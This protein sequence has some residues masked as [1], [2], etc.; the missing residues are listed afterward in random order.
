MSVSLSLLALSEQWLV[1]YRAHALYQAMLNICV[2]SMSRETTTPESGINGTLPGRADTLNMPSPS[3]DVASQSRG[4]ETGMVKRL[5]DEFRGLHEQRLRWLEA[6]TTASREELLQKKEDFLQS[7]VNDLTDQNQL[8]VETI[9]ELQMEADHNISNLGMKP[10]PSDHILDAEAKVA[11]SRS[12]LIALFERRREEREARVDQLTEELNGVKQ[13][14]KERDE[15]MRHLNQEVVGLRATQD[16]LTTT[17]AMKEKS[18][19]QLVQDNTLLEEALTSLQRKLQTSECMLTDVSETRDQTKSS[20][21]AERQQKQQ[22][23]DQLHQSRREVER[24]QQEVTRVHCAAEK[25]MQK[26]EM[27]KC[28]LVKELAQSKK[29]QSDCQTEL[30]H[31]EK[32]LEKQHQER[33]ELRAKMEEQSRECVHLNQTK[34]RLEAD[35]AESH[36]KLRIAHLEVR[37]RD[38]LILQ[39]RDEMK[40]AEQKHQGTQ[41]QVAA[42]E[43]ELRH[44]NH[45]VRGHQEEACQLSKRVRDA[46]RLKDQKERE[47][48]Q[49]HDQLRTSQQQAETTAGKLKKQEDETGLLHQR[50]RGAEEDLKD[51][52]LQVQEQKETVAIL[53]QKYAAAIDKLRESQAETHSATQEQAELERRYLEKVG[54]WESSQE[55]LDQLTDELQANQKLLRE[56][57]QQL[58]HSKSL[59]GSLQEQGDILN[60]QKLT[61][62]CDLRLYQQ[63]HSRSDEEYLRLQRHRQQL[64]RRC[65]EQV[66]RIAEC[67]KAILQMKSELE[68]QT[69]EKADLKQILARSHSMHLSSRGQLEQEVTRLKSQVSH[70]ELELADTQ[71]VHA[72]LL[73]RSEE[74]LEE[75][76][77]EAARGCRQADVQRGELLRLQ[78]EL[79]EEE[80]KV[81][82][83]AREMRSL[84]T[85]TGQLS[86]ELEELRGKRQATEEDLAARAEEVRR[87]EG[88]LNEAK[89]A[90]EKIRSVALELETEVVELRKKLQQAVDQKLKAERG[91]QDAQKQVDTLRSELEGAQSDNVNLRQESQLVMTHVNRWI[92]EQKASSGALTAQME[93]QHKVLLIVTKENEH[94]Q[95]ANDTLKVE[96]KRLREVVDEKERER[97]HFKAQIRARGIRQ[98]EK[99]MENQT[100]VVQNLSKIEQMQTRLRSNLEAIGMLNQQLNALSGENKRLRWQLEE[101]R[102]RRRQVEQLLPPPPAPQ[103]CSSI[104]LPASLGARPPPPLR[105]PSYIPPPPQSPGPGPSDRAH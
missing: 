26:R 29:Q 20:L 31:R 61:L 24:L 100:C 98:D 1:S 3:G 77:R 80:E 79:R 53:K 50:L 11:S 62:E 63:S 51:A 16:S 28:L 47:Q 27:K 45:K 4:T 2:P 48:Q 37:S 104:H 42:L 22:I 7:Y 58:E 44:L 103:R 78:D 68:R 56:S 40:T 83:A 60:Q 15:H 34:E 23:Q 41:G 52:S 5:L 8:L 85:Y 39:L 90:E 91:K 19:Q 88:C 54:Q 18:A 102:S 94:L 71:K 12:A 70:L 96:A 25:K 84:S 57:R 9:E 74:E 105:L 32:D 92:T 76:R 38:H 33:D 93:A 101:E 46:E 13:R 67:E 14:V 95:E 36:E 17:L 72:A 6:D 82:S 43:C 59:M 89:L 97:E 21:N 10:H 64:Q 99:T 69:Q 75:A 86:Q 30:L 66:K 81:M 35:L 87:M 65:I 73:R 55:A 49:L